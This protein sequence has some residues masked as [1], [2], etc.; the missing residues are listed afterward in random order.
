MTGESF[1]SEQNKY[2]TLDWGEIE[3]LPALTA[4]A[5]RAA[6]KSF[7]AGTGLG[8]DNI[9]PRAIARLSD[10]AIDTLAAILMNCE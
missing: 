2:P 4:D 6:A 10:E 5:I 7:P 3:E 1:G 9:S 8:V